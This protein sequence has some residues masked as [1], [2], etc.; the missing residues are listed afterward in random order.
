MNS[1]RFFAKKTVLVTGATGFIG[2]HLVRTLIDANARVTILTRPRASSWRLRDLNHKYQ[3]LTADLTHKSR[4]RR[5]LSDKHFSVVFH[6][7]AETNH[8]RT[9]KFLA[10]SF[11][12][13]LGGTINLTS[14]LL[15]QPPQV[16]VNVGTC[17]EY[18]DQKTPFFEN[19]RENP[20]SPYSASKVAATHYL[21]MFHRIFKFPVVTVRPFLTYGPGQLGDYLIPYCIQQ[22]LLTKPLITTHGTKT[23]EF[24]FVTDIVNGLLLTAATPQAVG[25]IIDLGTGQ[26]I[27]ISQVVK[28][29]LDLTHST[30]TWQSGTLPERPGETKRFYC[31]GGKA[32]KLLGWQP[33]TSLTLGLKKTIN[34]Y[35]KS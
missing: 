19:L 2:S 15:K 30:S 14:N 27:K 35:V 6:L 20:V 26:E 31:R 13:N 1:K 33:Q 3:T 23:R 22:A 17:E 21:E 25:E 34:W 5:V 18:G 32:K 28:T 7:A 24:H 29:I 8:E 12:V 9:G 10:K 4:L 11:R 16:L